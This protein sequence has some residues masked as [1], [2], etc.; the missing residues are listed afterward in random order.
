MRKMLLNELRLELQLVVPA[1]ARFLVADTRPPKEN[2]PKDQARNVPEHEKQ[3]DTVPM[4]PM[5]QNGLPFLP[6]SS[7]KGVLRSQ[8]ERIAATLN[9]GNCVCHLF[10]RLPQ[11]HQAP[12]PERLSCGDRFAIRKD[13][14]ERQGQSL[15]SPVFFRDACPACQTFGHPF[16]AGKLRIGDFTALNQVQLLSQTHVAIDRITSGASEHKLYGMEYV[17]NTVFSGEIVLEN[18][19]L[20]QVGW[21]GFLLRDLDDGLL[22][23]GHKVTSGSGVVTIQKLSA[24]WRQLRSGCSDSLQKIS[25]I[26]TLLSPEDRS[27]YGC[28][29]K[30]SLKTS[31]AH[32]EIEGPW[33]T[34]MIADKK[35]TLTY[36][37]SV[38]ARASDRLTHFNFPAEMQIPYL[39][40]LRVTSE[41]PQ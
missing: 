5:K 13:W 16:A 30:V 10:D 29:E 7:L 23:I 2:S 27:A 36:C 28:S 40:G 33:Q 17:S 6:G 20:W 19:S 39:E 8:A 21:L 41:V 9:P 14:A 32:W 25:G 37:L 26:G 4:K 35:K 31:G 24:R 18:F 15:E 38:A 11:N 3:P 34:F 12:L 22:R 1:E